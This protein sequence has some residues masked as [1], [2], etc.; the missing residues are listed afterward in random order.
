MS[1]QC[2]TEP[3]CDPKALASPQAPFL[4]TSILC[5]P[6]SHSLD[7]STFP[8]YPPVPV[9]GHFY[10]AVPATLVPVRPFCTQQSGILRMPD[11]ISG[12][13]CLLSSFCWLPGKVVFLTIPSAMSALPPTP[14]HHP[15][16]PAN[17]VLGPRASRLRPVLSQE[18]PPSRA[19][20]G[21]PCPPFVSQL[22]RRPQRVLFPKSKGS[23]PGLLSS[24]KQNKTKLFPH[25]MSP[26]RK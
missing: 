23:S 18:C 20:R 19:F 11:L 26:V 5:G 15:V 9:T 21:C 3:T 6:L 14:L 25:N 2:G 8:F 12:L 4:P 1:H 10:P 24:P 16:S 17:C 22:K 13:P 7:L